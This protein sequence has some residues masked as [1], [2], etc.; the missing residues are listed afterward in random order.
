M[1]EYFK[2]KW[3]NKN[4]KKGKSADE[5]LFRTERMEEPKEYGVEKHI[6]GTIF[7]PRWKSAKHNLCN[8]ILADSRAI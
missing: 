3:W 5:R 4:D 1:N 6:D 7:Y 2:W 8:Y